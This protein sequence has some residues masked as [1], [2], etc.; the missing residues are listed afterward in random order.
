MIS[1]TLLLLALLSL[2]SVRAKDEAVIEDEGKGGEGEEIPKEEEKK[3]E[4]PIS[5]KDTSRTAQLLNNVSSAE[6]FIDGAPVT[7]IGFLKDLEASDAE[8]FNDVV[9]TVR[10]LPFAV[11]YN[12]AVWEKYNITKNT[13][14]L[15]KKFDEGRADYE[16]KDGKLESNITN[17][18]QFL[19]HNE[20]HLVTEY[21]YLD[22]TQIFGSGIPIHLLFLVSK[23]S[24]KYQLLREPFQTVA[25][26]FRGK[27]I[28]I[29]VDT[30]VKENSRVSSYFHVKA[31]DLPVLCLYHVMTEAVDVMK[32]NDINPESIRKFC[33]N[34]MEGKEKSTE[35]PPK[36]SSEEL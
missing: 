30:D 29:L 24:K 13:I 18:I 16:V 21:N 25:P 35:K 4:R 31:A 12:A 15:F 17:I 32:V 11:T 33:N 19:R 5:P 20:M 6:A 27:V 10:N 22:A 9:Y 28:F 7:V 23:K 26:E 34:F 3:F 36:P 14:S 8:A 2:C 1:R